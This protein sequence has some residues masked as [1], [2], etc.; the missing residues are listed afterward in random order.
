MLAMG[1]EG[2]IPEHDHLVVTADL[3]EGAA[4]VISRIGGVAREPVPIGRYDA[5]RRIAH[6]FPSGVLARPAQQRA[7]CLLG[8]LAGHRTF[9]SC[10]HGCI[11]WATAPC[12]R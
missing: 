9:A 6:A 2:D 4:Q 7:H 11:S 12:D 3:L 10:R 1:L 8:R 5:R